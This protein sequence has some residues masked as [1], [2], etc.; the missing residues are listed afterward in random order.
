MIKKFDEFI[1]ESFYDENDGLT[2]TITKDISSST[3][4]R[5]EETNR[6]LV[7]PKR[8]LVKLFKALGED[9]EREIQN[10]IGDKNGILVTNMRKDR[11]FHTY[12]EKIL[13]DYPESFYLLTNVREGGWLE[14]EIVDNG[15]QNIIITPNTSKIIL[16]DKSDCATLNFATHGGG[17]R[18]ISSRFEH[19]GSI[20]FSKRIIILFDGKLSELYDITDY[21]YSKIIHNCQV[22]EIE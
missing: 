1:N 4:N 14:E 12:L 16:A 21:P 17:K 22:F 20:E 10:I 7:K 18:K 6:M 15:E 8:M 3:K 13:D 2:S 9:N 5:K 11:D 19:L